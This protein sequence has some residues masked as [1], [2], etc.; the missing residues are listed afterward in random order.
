MYATDLATPTDACHRHRSALAILGSRHCRMVKYSMV[1][2]PFVFRNARFRKK[3]KEGLGHAR[4]GEGSLAH[5]GG[6]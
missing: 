5:E 1:F 6:G 2:G 4:D 3:G